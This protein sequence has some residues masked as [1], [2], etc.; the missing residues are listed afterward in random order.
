MVVSFREGISVLNKAP[1]G[2]SGVSDQAQTSERGTLD[3]RTGLRKGHE[4]VFHKLT[5][6]RQL[7][8]SQRYKL[9]MEVTGQ[10]PRE[11]RSP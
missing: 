8:P 11:D 9:L 3:V 7:G 10:P 4:G 2:R 5:S 6:T 1:P